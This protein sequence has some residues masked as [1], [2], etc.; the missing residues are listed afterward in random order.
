MTKVPDLDLHGVK[1]E[2]AMMVVNIF[3]AYEKE[4]TIIKKG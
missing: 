3:L 4:S 2:D 1:H